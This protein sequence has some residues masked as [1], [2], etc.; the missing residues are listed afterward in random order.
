MKLA[1]VSFFSL[2]S[3]LGLVAIVSSCSHP[4]RISGAWQGNPAR[5]TVAGAEYANSTLTMDFAPL[6]NGTNSGDVN[7]SAV[8]DVQQA[9]NTASDNTF[10]EPY[11]TSI[12]AT[13]SI[14]GRYAFEER[15]DDDVMISFD[16]SS[17]TVN[18]D[19]SGV[20]FSENV[21]T[22]TE[23]ATRDSL[24]SAVAERWRVAITTAIR[25][26]FLRY[27]RID[28][29]KVHHS[30]MMSCEIADRDQTFRRVK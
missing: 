28:D 5:L 16:Q 15:D 9:M 18:V 3:V 24:A 11:I 29:I 17:L 8:I 10:Q 1:T 20:L 30:D 12:S 21:L 22:G 2:L 26:E 7:I 13:A 4:Q 27:S 14:D 19:P 25:D 6:N 23:Q